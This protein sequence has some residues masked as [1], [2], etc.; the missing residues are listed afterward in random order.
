MTNEEMKMKLE[1]FKKKLLE[2]ERESINNIN[3][4]DDKQMV[5]RIIRT[6]EEMMK[7]ANK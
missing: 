1:E 6:Y 5:S 7:D 4:I 2:S 3:K